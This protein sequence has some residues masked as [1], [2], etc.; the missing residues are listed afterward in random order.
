MS[1][2]FF[3][4]TA[5]YDYLIPGSGLYESFDLVALEKAEPV[6]EADYKDFFKDNIS[7]FCRSIDRVY[8]STRKR[9]IATAELI[10]NNPVATEDLNEIFFSM[11]D[12]ISKQKF[13]SLS[14][15][16]R[17]IVARRRFVKAL[18]SNKLRESFGSVLTRASNVIQLIKAVDGNTVFFSHG[19]FMKV[20]ESLVRNQLIIKKPKRLLKYFDGSSE[21]FQFGEGFVLAKR[22]SILSFI[23][24]IR[25]KD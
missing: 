3:F 9:G 7:R 19:F 1:L 25:K 24:Y 12:F 13:Y 18:V 20:V 2:A 15:S 16:K 21:T 22:K 8:C 11:N 5:P 10:T 14:E 23:S 17:L 6:P 4:R